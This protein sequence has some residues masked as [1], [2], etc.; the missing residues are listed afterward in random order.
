[1]KFQRDLCQILAASFMCGVS[2][3]AETI[4]EEDFAGASVAS[5]AS[6]GWVFDTEGTVE[7]GAMSR[8]DFLR[9]GGVTATPPT[10]T[11]PFGVAVANGTLKIAMGSTTSRAG[12]HVR[13]MDGETE[14]FGL[15]V[16]SK[17]EVTVHADTSTFFNQTNLPGLDVSVLGK[18]AMGYSGH[19]VASFTWSTS[20]DG[21]ARLNCTLDQPE[22]NADGGFDALEIDGL[23]F[24]ADGVPDTVVVETKAHDAGSRDVLI[25]NLSVHTVLAEPG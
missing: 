16:N 23:A 9:M 1:M 10:L 22:S 6:E 12:I 11:K 20:T 17:N 5:L 7:F 14:L 25:Y 15:E 21:D 19:L 3:T 2:A 13:V 4:F 18:D 24:K 8:D